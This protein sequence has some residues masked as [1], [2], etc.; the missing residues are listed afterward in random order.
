MHCETGIKV[1]RS[2]SSSKKKNARDGGQ[3]HQF[4]MNH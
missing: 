4:I 1:V 3:I 2:E